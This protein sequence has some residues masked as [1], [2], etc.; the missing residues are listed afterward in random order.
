MNQPIEI[1]RS[2][3]IAAAINSIKV[4]HGQIRQDA[5]APG[6]AL[7]YGGT[8]TTLMRNCGFPQSEAKGIV[9]NYNVMYAVSMAWTA[10]RI[11]EASKNGYV[12]AAFGLRVRT[13]LLKR[14]V[15]G[16]RNAPYEAKKEARTAGNALGQSWCLLNNRAAN[17][18]MERLWGTEFE[19]KILPSAMIHDATYFLIADDVE[20]IKWLN[21]NLIE[22]MEWQEDPEIQHPT[23]HLGANLDIHYKNWSQP[24]ELPNQATIQEIRKTCVSGAYRWDNPE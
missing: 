10:E 22:C 12:T 23:V 15:L 13:P 21:D 17:A 4:D 11:R 7:Q 3:Y 6:F 20:V 19:T 9:S 8:F 5:K 14:T 18:L 24:I 16:S 2:E 1:S